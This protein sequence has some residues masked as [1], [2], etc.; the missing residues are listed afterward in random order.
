MNYEENTKKLEEII[1]KLENEDISL[2]DSSKLFEEGIKLAKE[3]YSQLEE[4]KGKILKIKQNQE[5]FF[6]D[7]I[8]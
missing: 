8:N 2:S 6:E 3:C 4:Q 5:I 1:N 7:E